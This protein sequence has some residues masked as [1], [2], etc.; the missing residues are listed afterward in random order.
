M[1]VTDQSANPLLT[2]VFCIKPAW[3]KWSLKVCEDEILPTKM[4]SDKFNHFAAL[5]QFFPES[6]FLC[7]FYIHSNV[8]SNYLATTEKQWGWN[9]PSI[10]ACSLIMEEIYLA[11]VCSF[12][13]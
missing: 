4:K 13:C 8:T 11:V 9:S 12:S 1:P 7:D 10:L 6:T 3:M 5:E 2:D